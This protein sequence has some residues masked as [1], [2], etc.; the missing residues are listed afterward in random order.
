MIWVINCLIS[1]NNVEILIFSH[2][3]IGSV[4]LDYIE[5]IVEYTSIRL[6]MAKNYSSLC[7]KTDRKLIKFLNERIN[8][9]KLQKL[10]KLTMAI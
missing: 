5:S 4:A 8:I 3:D 10:Q 2:I 7:D 1:K 9:K 6:I